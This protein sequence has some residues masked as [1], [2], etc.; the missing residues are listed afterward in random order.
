MEA[1]EELKRNLQGDV[2]GHGSKRRRTAV[3]LRESKLGFKLVKKDEGLALV[4][5]GA[6]NVNN[7]K[8]GLFGLWTADTQLKKK[9]DGFP[10]SLSMKTH[11]YDLENE[12][13]FALDKYIQDGH[14]TK[15][16]WT[17]KAYPAGTLPNVW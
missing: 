16:I 4:N 7:P 10:Y 13:K 6:A 9:G 11:I 8:D 12:K 5:A 1:V 17:Y 15:C 3:V 2:R 14:E